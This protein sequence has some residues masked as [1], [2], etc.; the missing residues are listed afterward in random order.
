MILKVFEFLIGFLVGLVGLI[1]DSLLSLIPPSI[2]PDLSVVSGYI[3]NFWSFIFGWFNW[4]RDAL[5]IDSLSITL[6]IDIL[7]IS[8]LYK[9]VVTLIKIIVDWIRE[10]F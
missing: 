1:I 6:I 10:L 5:M 7:T 9:P 8:L 3:N 2:V 4:V